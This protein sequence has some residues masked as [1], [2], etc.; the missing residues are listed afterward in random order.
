[1][2]MGRH[3]AG[4]LLIRPCRLPQYRLPAAAIFPIRPIAC[5][6]DGS[7]SGNAV[8]PNGRLPCRLPLSLILVDIVGPLLSPDDNMRQNFLHMFGSEQYDWE[9][10][11]RLLSGSKALDVE[12][13]TAK[14]TLNGGRAAFFAYNMLQY[15]S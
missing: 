1:M 2:R 3:L 8:Q 7:V 9:L 10:S 4:L 15:E 6:P 12:F 14:K 5:G 11:A 13:R